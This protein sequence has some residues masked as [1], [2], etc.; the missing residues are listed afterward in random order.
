MKKLLAFLC[1]VTIVCTGNTMYMYNKSSSTEFSASAVS[2]KFVFTDI[3]ENV[4][5]FDDGVPKLVLFGN[6]GCVY[7]Q[8]TLKSISESKWFEENNIQVLYADVLNNSIEDVKGLSDIVGSDFIH[9]CSE[10]NNSNISYTEIY[11]Y[12]ASFNI[13][14]VFPTS[15]YFDGDGKISGML[16]GMKSE[17]ELIEFCKTPSEV[18]NDN[19]VPE[20]ELIVTEK[21]EIEF[22]EYSEDV[23]SYKELEDGTI[24]IT[25]CRQRIEYLKIP[26]DIG[27][28][29]VTS[30]GDSAFVGYDSMWGHYL[31]AVYIPD[32]VI[33]VGESCFLSQTELSYIRIPESL[34]SIGNF[35]FNVTAW[36][37]NEG[38]K[39]NGAP[40]TINDIVIEGMY[41]FVNVEIPE[42]AKKINYGAFF[43]SECR[44]VLVPDSITYIDDSVFDKGSDITFYCN[45]GSYAEEYANKKGFTCINDISKFSK[46]GNA[47]EIEKEFCIIADSNC[48][49]YRSYSAQLAKSA[50]FENADG[51]YTFVQGDS[52]RAFP[53]V[54]ISILDKTIN[55]L[56][57]L[58][59]FALPMIG[60]WGSCYS[61][62]E[63][64]FL[65]LGRDNTNAEADAEMIRVCKYSKN[66]DYID[67]FS[68]NA[69]EVND[70]FLSINDIFESGNLSITE[71]DGQ[72]YVYTSRLMFKSSDGKNHQ[73]NCLFIIDE[74]TMEGYQSKSN[75]VSHSFNQLIEADEDGV[76]LVDHG[77]GNP[78]S[79]TLSRDCNERITVQP[80][81]GI[82]G[83]NN[84]GLELG[85]LALTKE[86]A[87]IGYTSIDQENAESYDEQKNL[88]VAAVN[89][90]LSD[91]TI[92]Q[93]TDYKKTDEIEIYP[94]H[95]ISIGNNVIVMWNEMDADSN[96]TFKLL[97]LSAAG[98][99]ESEIVSFND[100]RTAGYSPIA[101]SD[102]MIRWVTAEDLS[103]D[104]F[105]PDLHPYLYTLNPDTLET[106]KIKAD[107]ENSAS[108]VTTT[109]TSATTTTVITTVTTT[110]G[111][112]TSDSAGDVNHDG[113]INLLDVVLL[114]KYIVGGYGVEVD[115]KDGDVNND[116]TIN[117]ADVVKIRRIIVGGYNQ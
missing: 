18:V 112:N 4:F 110:S 47:L 16:S 107:S 79:I 82:K 2:D 95:V 81:T 94:P 90:D 104:Y 46:D 102:G 70:L 66:W 27:G 88:Y 103:A 51:S 23:F 57:P 114:R 96:F 22:P 73:S 100:I 34:T 87:V 39:A 32:T 72:L 8:Y 62:S 117:L 44:N 84:T 50:F 99:I 83:D 92:V 63:Y 17:E 97:K 21:T 43:D 6:V 26:A 89:K 58:K 61:G 10:E 56:Q 76:Y 36:L 113:N 13:E 93:I 98:E 20:K 28:K 108:T 59:S 14:N 54:N 42:G 80:I 45:E 48:N 105:K 41:C 78:R 91:K 19:A 30:L 11:R 68:C 116:G 24:E 15:V 64:N 109:T 33:S 71:K 9:F 29:K 86:K 111:E 1:A 101:C 37:E 106:I 3:D 49:C 55:S 35:A 60:K 53:S 74:E 69:V 115:L 40:V 25:G 65:I 67:S 38:I 52:S 7:T 12:T 85:G 75:Y 77:D 5:S 31:K